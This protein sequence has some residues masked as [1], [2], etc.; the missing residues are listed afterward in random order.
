MSSSSFKPPPSLPSYHLQHPPQVLNSM[1]V[2]QEHFKY[3]LG[4]SNPSSLRET[5][6]EVSNSTTHPPTHLLVR[7]IRLLLFYLPT[8]PPTQTGAQHQL[9]RHWGAGER[10][11]RAPGTR[12]VP[13][14]APREGKKAI[15]PPTHPPTHLLIHPPTHL[16][17]YLPKG[18]RQ[19]PTHPSTKSS[20]SFQPPRSPP[21]SYQPTHPPT[22]PP[23]PSSSRN[24]AC[25]LPAVSSSMGLLAAARPSWPRPSPTNARPTSSPSR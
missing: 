15:Y 25:L 24:S 6:V 19:P 17:I 14:R 7:S 11:A 16:P 3:A 1:A 10:Q 13:R 12:P 4:V 2:S 9:G 22:H 20:T 23:L 8:H 5:V 18:R 21:P